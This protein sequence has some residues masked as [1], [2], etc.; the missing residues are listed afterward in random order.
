[1]RFPALMCGLA[2]ATLCFG[3]VAHG[4]AKS[5]RSKPTTPASA[6]KKASSK[7]KA[8][9]ATA[10]V[11]P[12]VPAAPEPAIAPL[13]PPE[14]DASVAPLVVP[15]DSTAAE[16]GSRTLEAFGASDLPPTPAT[17]TEAPA[18]AA[19]SVKAEPAD[20]ARPS[21]HLAPR[22]G[23]GYTSEPD[24]G[25]ATPTFD[26]GLGLEYAFNDE[27]S[28]RLAAHGHLY[29]RGYLTTRPDLSLQGPAQVTLDEQKV[30]AE[31]LFAYELPG[32]I[33]F[34]RPWL[35][36]AALVGPSARFFFNDSLRSQAAGVAAGL[37]TSFAF[38]PQLDLSLQGIYGYNLLQHA[39]KDEV[40]LNA[41]GGPLAY[42]SYGASLGLRLAP[43]TRFGI[44][45][46]GELVVLA[47]SM[48]LYHSMAFVFDVAL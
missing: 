9:D 42:D 21:L 34:E 45:Y 26:A 29:Q 37:R 5:Q 27:A 23:F 12:L 28:L 24:L 16:P 3:T 17:R 22:V 18:A 31:L 43:G 1:M 4:A 11:A 32:L 44:G 15:L 35:R 40:Q 25:P 6:K 36:L 13:T 41:L 14:A 39:A 47:S 8:A 7:A 48:R 10:T 20:S 46:E 2:A 30:G 33:G 38:S 19:V